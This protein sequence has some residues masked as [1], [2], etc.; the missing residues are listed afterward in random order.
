MANIMI[1]Y[2]YQFIP[3]EFRNYL[4]EGLT[5]SKLSETEAI[6]NFYYVLPVAKSYPTLRCNTLHRFIFNLYSKQK[7][8]PI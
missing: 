2:S 5:V 7:C 8:S 4:D 1:P 3:E 6:Y